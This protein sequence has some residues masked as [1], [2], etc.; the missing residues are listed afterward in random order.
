M[1]QLSDLQA[2]LQAQL[3]G[4]K[5]HSEP[6]IFPDSL[7]QIIKA[8]GVAPAQRLRVYTSG[9]YL[10]LLECLKGDFPVLQGFLSDE[11]FGIFAKGYIY[12][13]GSQSYSLLDFSKNFPDFLRQMSPPANTDEERYRYLF[14]YELARIERLLIEVATDKG[15]ETDEAMNLPAGANN[16]WTGFSEDSYLQTPPCLRLMEAHFDL[17]A[18]LDDPQPVE[19]RAIPEPSQTYIAL[20][21]RQYRLHKTK[22]EPW[23]YYWLSYIKEGNTSYQ[24]LLEQTALASQKQLGEL[25]ADLL[26][27][28]P[29]CEAQQLVKQTFSP[30]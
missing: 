23:Q 5:D 29:F 6:S 22:L 9:Y 18:F 17:C 4:K 10:R 27:F 19:Q 30:L 2:W 15:F 25:R 7:D 14:P 24:S 12:S 11:V 3:T 28:V 26:F 8:N 13:V 20:Y 1:S 16:F 21:R